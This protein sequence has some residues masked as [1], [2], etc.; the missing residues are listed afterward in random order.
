VGL[1]LFFAAYEPSVGDSLWAVDLCDRAPPLVDCPADLEFEAT[2]FPGTPVRYAVSATDDLTD[3][4][5]IEFSHPPGTA[6]P[7]GVTPVTVQARDEAGNVATCTFQVTMRDTGAP[8]ITCPRNV[9]A[10]ATS[11]EGAVIDY[12]EVKVA[13]VASQVTLA[14][15]PPEGSLF[16]A[17]ESTRVTVTATDSAGN[18]ATCQ[19]TVTVEPLPEE[20]EESG[21][22]CG[23]PAGGGLAWGSLLLLALIR[24]SRA[25]ARG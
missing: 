5:T 6:F 16:P 13:D 24:R 20:E 12:P 21:C 10:E 3:E 17:N 25:R 19:F 18:T 23:T 2:A 11:A 22:G 9:V 1:K 4:P 8:A 7:V 14:Y 15:E